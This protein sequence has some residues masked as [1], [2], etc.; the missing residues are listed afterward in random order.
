MQEI[1]ILRKLYNSEN[2]VHLYEVYETDQKVIFVMTLA[3]GGELSEVYN[4]KGVFTL[5]ESLEVGKQL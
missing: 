1:K 4:E 5:Q 2:I 3:E